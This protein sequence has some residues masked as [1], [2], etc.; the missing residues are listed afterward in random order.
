MD[1]I[2]APTVQDNRIAK[3]SLRKKVLAAGSGC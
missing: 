1:P 2:P 3:V